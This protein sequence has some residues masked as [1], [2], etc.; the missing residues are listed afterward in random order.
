MPFR[1]NF[2]TAQR[3]PTTYR[4]L[5]SG[6]DLKTAKNKVQKKNVSAKVDPPKIKAPVSQRPEGRSEPDRVPGV[7]D[8]SFKNKFTADLGEITRRDLTSGPALK[9]AGIGFALGGGSIVGAVVGGVRGAMEV[10]NAR[11]QRE[12]AASR[13]SFV[14]TGGPNQRPDAPVAPS[15][16]SSNVVTGAQRNIGGEGGGVEAGIRG[17]GGR[18]SESFGPSGRGSGG[19]DNGGFSRDKDFGGWT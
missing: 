11:N 1:N 12:R 14:D 17:P 16:P 3:G 19:F 8:G 4:F 18:G 7:P 10:A 9:Q 2:I 6:D 13:Q 15:R 5:G